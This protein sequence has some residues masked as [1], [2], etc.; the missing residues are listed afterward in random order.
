MGGGEANSEGGISASLSHGEGGPS[1]KNCSL[2]TCHSDTLSGRTGSKT[3]DVADGIN[4][5]GWGKEENKKG[6][7]RQIG[8][9]GSGFRALTFG[10]V[11]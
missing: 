3:Q 5:R 10:M 7:T 4:G 8:N 2:G 11:V 9:L 1:P 6:C